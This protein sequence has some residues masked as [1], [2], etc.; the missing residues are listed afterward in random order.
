MPERDFEVWKPDFKS[1]EEVQRELVHAGF[2][3]EP[4]GY[5][6]VSLALTA[7]VNRHGIGYGGED[8]YE[9]EDRHLPVITQYIDATLIYDKY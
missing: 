3:D 9:I 7:I 8:K 2:F 5:I 6:D 1:V 4:P